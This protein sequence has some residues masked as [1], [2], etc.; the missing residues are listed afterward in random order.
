VRR[1]VAVVLPLLRIEL[2]RESLHAGQGPLALVVARP[3]SVVQD[4]RSLL[5]NS[6]LDEVCPQAYAHGIRRGQTV[7][8][9]RARCAEVTVRVVPLDAVTGE[10]ERVAE[11]LLSYGATTSFDL[12][13]DVVWVDVTGCAHLHRDADDPTGDQPLVRHIHERIQAMGHACRIALADGPLFAAAV[14][15]GGGR[16]MP[17]VVPPGKSLAALN[18]LSIAVLP[19]EAETVRRLRHMG[20]HTVSHLRR[21]PRRS[22]AARLG[23]NAVQV[24]QL[25]AGD[26]P[27]PLRAHVPPEIPEESTTLDSG[28]EATEALLFVLKGLTG[29]LSHRLAGRAMAAT[30]LELILG[31]DRALTSG[32][33]RVTLSLPLA[34]PLVEAPDLLG[35]LRSR[36]E[37]FAAQ[38]PI[39]TVTLRA[40][41]MS[42]R[43]AT[44]LHLFVPE[45]KAERTL[46]RLVAE[47][48]AELGPGHVGTL[49]LSNRWLPEE[50]SFIVP[51][52]EARVRISH[53]L[54][55]PSSPRGALLSGELEPTRLLAT[56]A[57]VELAGASR[58]CGRRQFVEWWTHDDRSPRDYATAW[59]EPVSAMAWVELHTRSGRAWVRG[60]MD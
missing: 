46:P 35:V 53:A 11:A 17:V 3:G 24:M 7:A 6:R 33:P 1:I 38:A 48:E 51:I 54:P 50:R 57:P 16:A 43:T 9:A 40:P 31:L 60:W 8:A 18:E 4:D 59:V 42:A 28:I 12:E 22:L 45:A 39:L 37:S 52:G 10:L 41:Q 47:L 49:A 56:P 30:E 26:D 44:P 25:L 55:S 32:A 20:L 14:A 34:A 19:L 58:L 2:A 15:R 36:L 29:K 13:E 23:P 27:T 5:G 21:L